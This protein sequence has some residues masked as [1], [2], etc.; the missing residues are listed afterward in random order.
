MSTIIV[1]RIGDSITG[2]YNGIAYGV[3]F[4]DEKYAAMK[5]LEAQ[6]PSAKTPSD[7]KEIVEKFEAYTKENYKEL[8]EHAQGG[9]YLWVNP[10]TGHVYLSINGK[11]STE[12]L[13]QSLV[14]RIIYSVEK[15]IDI[16]PLIKCWTRFM[17]NPWYSADKANL[18]AEYINTTVVNHELRDSLM[19]EH[20]LSWE[21]ATQRAT[22]YDLS[23]T[24]EGLLATYKVVREID[25]K[26]VTDTDSEDGVK[27]IDRFDYVVDEFTGLK[28]YTKPEFLEQRVFEPC[29]Q[30]QSGDAF[31]SGSYEGHV[32]RVG[33]PV[34][35]DNWDKVNTDDYSSCV[36][37]LH[38]GGLRY[39]K[40][41]QTEDTITLNV[42]VDPAHIGGIDHEGTGA[43]RVLKYFPHSAL[44]GMT[45]NL[46]HSSEYAKLTD[47][48]YADLVTKAVE[49][50]QQDMDKIAENLDAKK[51]LM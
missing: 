28:T 27:K 3:Q 39:I 4:S 1:N 38:I 51:N 12:R 35:L 25:W 33:Q 17:R 48:E 8:V 41:Y 50:S 47:A 18:F 42:F 44:E 30:R 6:V 36:K 21:I 26:Y 49:A 34:F 40:G 11:A 37:G 46:Y 7:L 2:A 20:G 9:K 5:E 15:K 22:M 13:P 10:H 45:Q 14:D 31:F 23:F 24:Q 16:T 32:V 19:N 43:L 29:L